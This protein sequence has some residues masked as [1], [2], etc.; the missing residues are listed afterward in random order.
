[1]TRPLSALSRTFR[2]WTPVLVAFFA[3]AGPGA[4]SEAAGGAAGQRGRDLRRRLL[5]VHGAAV[6]Q[7]RRRARDHVRLHGRH[8]EEAD[9]RGR[10]RRQHRPR[11]GGAGPLRPEEGHLREAA[12]GLLA[13]HRSDGQG[14]PV[15]RR[16][17]PVP[18]GDLRAHRRAA[19][20][21]R[22]LQGALEKTKPFKEPIVT[23][24]VAATEFWPAEEYH[25]DY[26]IKNPIRYNYYRTGCGRDARLKQLWG[27]RCTHC[28]SEAPWK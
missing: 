5:L 12:R 11:R 2:R 1:M 23:P 26:Y 28:P 16:R 15:L 18:D 27:S 8:G 7:A 25:Q 13:Q 10:I 22:K 6:R 3:V 14:P 17:H 4:D 9:L 19:R 21:R 24:I 20:G